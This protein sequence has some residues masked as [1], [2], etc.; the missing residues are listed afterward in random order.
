MSDTGSGKG[1]LYR[2]YGFWVSVALESAWQVEY[3]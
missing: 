3:E 1:A 2:S